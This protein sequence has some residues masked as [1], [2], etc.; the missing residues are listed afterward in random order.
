VIGVDKGHFPTK[1]TEPK[2]LNPSILALPR[3][4]PERLASPAGCL[5]Y[6]SDQPASPGEAGASTETN[7]EANG[8]ASLAA[9]LIAA[10]DV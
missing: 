2:D 8:E 3:C 9:L 1:K 7:K 6:G 5:F 4:S 10:A